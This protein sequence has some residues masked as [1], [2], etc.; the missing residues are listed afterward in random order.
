[1]FV[2]I[3]NREFLWN[4]LVDTVDD[5]FKIERE[6]RVR[7]VG[8]VL[9]EGRIDTFPQPAATLLE[10]WRGDSASSFER[11]HA[12]LQTIRRRAEVRVIPTQGGYHIDVAVYKELE[13]LT[14]PDV[15][16]AGKSIK[17]NESSL[18]RSDLEDVS[19]DL[20]PFTTGWIP[21]G[22]EPAL[23][24]KILVNLRARLGGG[25]LPQQPTRVGVRPNE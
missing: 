25:V 18:V 3:A 19:E 22:R 10:P 5:Y 24:Q 16:T 13:D 11:L 14:Q 2:P 17:R 21:L 1:M 23:E 9:T 8:N 4:Q 15:S 12:T 7:H 20:G 6:E